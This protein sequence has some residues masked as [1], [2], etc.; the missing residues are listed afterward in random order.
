MH[1]IIHKVTVILLMGN[2]AI[3]IYASVLYH[4]PQIKL[5]DILRTYPIIS[6]QMNFK[7]CYS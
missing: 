7:I 4:T 3:L 5:P 2:A 6:K 1:T